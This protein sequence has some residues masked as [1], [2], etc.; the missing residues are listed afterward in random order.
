MMGVAN[1]IG[2]TITPEMR[3][4]LNNIDNALKLQ[5]FKQIYEMDFEKAF[6]AVR[7]LT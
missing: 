7:L 3:L 2:H 4:K 1:K 6:L 5:D